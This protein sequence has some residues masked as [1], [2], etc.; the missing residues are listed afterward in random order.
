MNAFNNNTTLTS[1]TIGTYGNSN[2][3]SI[4]QNAFRA[5]SNLTTINI[6]EKPSSINNAAFRDVNSSCVMNVVW[7]EGE[8]SGFPGSYYPG[9]VNYDYVPPQS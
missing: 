9:T 2:L 8:V 3:Q 4:G 7:S 6:L 5:C 1:V